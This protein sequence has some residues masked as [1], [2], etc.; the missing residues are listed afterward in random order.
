MPRDIARLLP[1]VYPKIRVDNGGVKGGQFELA[2]GGKA[3]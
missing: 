1:H 2:R 3:F